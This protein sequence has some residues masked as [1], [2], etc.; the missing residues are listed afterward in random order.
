LQEKLPNDFTRL[1]TTSGTGHLFFGAL[2]LPGGAILRAVAA[3]LS[4]D[5]QMLIRTMQSIIDDVDQAVA[6]YETYLP[7]G[8]DPDLIHRVNGASVHPAFNIISDALHR[9]ALMALCRIWDARDDT[10][11]L[12]SLASELRK[13]KVVCDLVNAGHKISAPQL[14]AW[15]SEIG[16]AKNSTELSA[17]MRARHRALAHT[18]NP[19]KQY[20]GKARPANFGDERR[21]LEQTISLVEKA[22]SFVGYSHFTPF[23][24]QRKIRRA[25]AEK[26]WGA[27]GAH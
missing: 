9:N 11:N 4:K 22:A 21:V 19:N 12:N 27:I 5:Y 16:K 15:L 3:A 6:F 18:A 8:K 23:H 7:T 10:A 2:E 26:F 20:K 17:L 13:P 24:E 1:F 25:H 14:R